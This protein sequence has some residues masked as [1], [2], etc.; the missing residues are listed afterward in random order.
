L[1]KVKRDAFLSDDSYAPWLRLKDYNDAIPGLGNIGRMVDLSQMKA[2]H[3][4]QHILQLEVGL[5]C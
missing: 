1:S 3:L 5:K 2:I 4:Y